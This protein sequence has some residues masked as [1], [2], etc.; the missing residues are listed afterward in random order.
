MW[1]PSEKALFVS[2]SFEM[3]HANCRS[4]RD[5]MVVMVRY[6]V[7]IILVI[8]VFFL[9]NRASLKDEIFLFGAIGVVVIAAMSVMSIHRIYKNISQSKQILAALETAMEFHTRGS[10]LP[11]STL[12]PQDSAS[13]KKLEEGWHDR[14]KKHIYTMFILLTSAFSLAAIYTTWQ[15]W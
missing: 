1:A 8:G 2:K 14:H 13:L 10:Y 3:M 11:E 6:V 9:T 7:T 15:Q 5:R 12:Y 4:A